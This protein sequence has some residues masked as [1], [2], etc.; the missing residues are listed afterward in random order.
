M[1]SNDLFLGVKYWW[2]VSS[3]STGAWSYTSLDANPQTVCNDGVHNSATK[4]DDH[5]HSVLPNDAKTLDH[6]KKPP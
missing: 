3:F 2:S 5:P 4:W 6:P 1:P